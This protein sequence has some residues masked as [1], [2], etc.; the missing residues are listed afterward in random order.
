MKSHV[1]HITSVHPRYDI[2]IFV[3]ESISLAEHNYL[4]SLIVGDDLGD[5]TLNKVNIYGVGTI[6]NRYLRFLG[7]SYRIYKKIVDLKPDYIHLHDPE[8]LFLGFYLSVFLNYKVVYDVHEDLPKQIIN[9]HWI[10]K[11]FRSIV[12]KCANLIELFISKRIY[13]VVCATGQIAKRFSGVNKNTIVL[14]NYPKLSELAIDNIDLAQRDDCVCYIGSI[15]R[16]RGILQLI[17]S[18]QINNVRLKLAGVFSGDVNLELI[19]SYDDKGLVDYL[20]VLDRTEIKLLLGMVKIGIVTL[21]PTPSYVESLPI[22]LFEYMLAGIPVIASNF[23][24]WQDIINNAQCGICVDPLDPLAIAKAIDELLTNQSLALQ[25][26]NNG[27]R[28]VMD[29]YNWE[30]EVNKLIDFYSNS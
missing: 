2:R 19:R 11:Y 23:P 12:A 27:K 21:L 3:K 24:L 29:K 28:E 30:H 25:M 4:T 15:S 17:K 16:T 10:P 7:S 9:K 20:G 18:L 26:G 14:Y 5:E 22:K 8:L 6:A 13:G 1:C